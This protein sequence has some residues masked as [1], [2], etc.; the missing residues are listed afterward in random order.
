MFNSYHLK[1]QDVLVLLKLQV[2]CAPWTNRS[3]AAELFISTSEVSTGLKRVESARLFDPR[4]R[5]PIRRSLE[6]FLIH[7]VKY[8]YPV[9]RGGLIRGMPTS[10]A[11]QPL[12]NIIVQPNELPPVWPDPLGTLQGYAFSPL[13]R[14]VP[15]AAAAD[16]K[17]YEMLALVDAIRDGR[18]RETEIAVQELKDRF[19]S[20]SHREI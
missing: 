17:L 12:R 11:A 1:P 8:A 20:S 5:R 4:R 2:T 9:Q 7:G 6:E 13:Y 19:C 10:Y 14:S 16:S 18:A 3:L 15:Q